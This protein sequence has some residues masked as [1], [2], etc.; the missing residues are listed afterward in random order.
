[1]VLP[2]LLTVQVGEFTG[3]LTMTAGEV[4]VAASTR[5]GAEN[6]AIAVSRPGVSKIFFMV[7]PL[8]SLR[9]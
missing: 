8:I 3:R 9:G 1:M 6:A 5:V 2:L 4:A 7:I